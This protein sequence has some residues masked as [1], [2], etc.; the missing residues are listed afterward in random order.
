MPGARLRFM[1]AIWNSYSKSLTARRPR[2][3]SRSRRAGEVGEQPVERPHLHAGIVDRLPDQRHA[4]LEGEERLLRQ[5]HRH[6]DDHAVGE[7]PGAADEVLVTARDRVE[8]PG[9]NGDAGPGSR[10]GA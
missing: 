9:V 4:L 6:G 1:S 8:R 10:H 7:G 5:V 3:I 2:T